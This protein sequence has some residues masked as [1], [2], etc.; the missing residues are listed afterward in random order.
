MNTVGYVLLSIIIVIVIFILSLGVYFWTKH[1]Q[2]Q[3]RE[4]SLNRNLNKLNDNYE[5]LT[6]KL[7][8]ITEI[9][10]NL[11]NL[12]NK[13]NINDA[14]GLDLSKQKEESTNLWKVTQYGGQV[15][16]GRTFED[17]RNEI[18]NLLKFT[19]N[20]QEIVEDETRYSCRFDSCG[21]TW[22]KNSNKMILQSMDKTAI[23]EVLQDLGLYD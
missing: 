19:K 4:E 1:K 11:S 9:L 6:K 17:N 14:K 23:K 3:S 12:N 18:L 15:T 10:D 7:D 16:Y 20:Y 13:S 5:I 8:Q 21:I 2:N 22:Y